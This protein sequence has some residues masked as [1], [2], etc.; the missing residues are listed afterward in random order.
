LVDNI[1]IAFIYDSAHFD[2]VNLITASDILTNVIWEDEG[3]YVWLSADLLNS[4][5]NLNLKNLATVVLKASN[6]GTARFDFQ[7]LVPSNSFNQRSTFALW[8]NVDVLGDYNNSEDGVV[9]AS[10]IVADPQNDIPAY[11]VV[12]GDNIISKG[13]DY[14][15]AIV[16]LTN[17]IIDPDYISIE[18]AWNPADFLYK[19]YEIISSTASFS[20][21]IDTNTGVLILSSDNIN[22][23]DCA[24]TVA[25][26]RLTAIH[27][28][29]TQIELIAPELSAGDG[30]ILL[31]AQANDLLGSADNPN[32]GM[33]GKSIIITETE[34]FMLDFY[35]EISKVKPGEEFF[36]DI[37]LTNLADG[38]LYSNVA[39]MFEYDVDD[40]VILDMSN[41]L[42]A[43][44]VCIEKTNF[45]DFCSM[46]FVWNQPTNV[47]GVLATIKA[48]TISDFPIDF[49]FSFNNI[50]IG[51]FPGSYALNGNEDVL[52]SPEF[53]EDGVGD[54]L[55]LDNDGLP[56]GATLHFFSKTNV[57]VG[58]IF[59][60]QIFLSNSAAV[61]VTGLNLI[62]EVEKESFEVESISQGNLGGIVEI[63]DIDNMYGLVH[64]RESFDVPTLVS[65]VV[66][67]LKMFT[68]GGLNLGTI[69]SLAPSGEFDDDGTFVR[70]N[71]IDVLGWAD[72]EN[73][74]GADTL[75][76]IEVSENDFPILILDDYN[77]YEINSFGSMVVGDLGVAYLENRNIKTDSL[78]WKIEQVKG[79]KAE[80]AQV[81]PVP[82]YSLLIYPKVGSVGTQIFKVTVTDYENSSL[83]SYDYVGLI[84]D[85]TEELIYPAATDKI[86][87]TKPDYS[88]NSKSGKCSFENG[89]FNITGGSDKDSLIIKSIGNYESI[90]SDNGLKKLSFNGSLNNLNIDG[91]IGSIIVKNGNLGNVTAESIKKISITAPRHYVKDEAIFDDIIDEPQGL[92]GSVTC[93]G[94]IGTIIVKSGDVGALDDREDYGQ[95]IISKNGSIGKI[96]T[97]GKKR[98]WFEKDYGLNRY[99]GGGNIYANILAPNGSIKN[100]MANNNIGWD[101]IDQPAIISAANDIKSIKLVWK[102]VRD[103]DAPTFFANVFSTS[104]VGRITIKS[105]NFG[106]DDLQTTIKADSIKSVKCKLW[107]DY[108]LDDG[109][110]WVDIYGGEFYANIIAENS[111]GS[112]GGGGDYFT[113]RILS[114]GDIKNIVYKGYK[115]EEGDLWGGDIEESFIAAGLNAD[116]SRSIGSIKSVKA[117]NNILD[118]TIQAGCVY[119]DPTPGYL[120]TIKKISAKASITDSVI[121]SLE[122]PKFSNKQA[123]AR[124]TYYINGTKQ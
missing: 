36:F 110:P 7:F 121:G 21:N 78:I 52:G 116:G 38:F 112:V 118:S 64:Y 93:E 96:I 55:D 98:Q 24:G 33:F 30:T 80:F 3:G 94:D 89:V 34:A 81:M 71:N 106:T 92:V 56:F 111:I 4:V 8:N 1:G 68:R 40:V 95:T 27:E 32:D 51:V 6:Q 72:D 65:G 57:S 87:Y 18:F 62:F 58:E 77:E 73:D 88:Y 123:R 59:D 42:L 120:G 48:I 97:K 26:V 99:F 25:V 119:A 113:S 19:N 17:L 75:I 11:M 29:S 102:K 44:A 84:I 13:V 115:D 85:P 5:S 43:N 101:N 53:D 22:I 28:G 9:G 105:A 47:L 114:G 117:G 122:R 109:D 70:N 31:D 124:I 12:K 107:R 83:Y 49:M 54:D 76:D 86:T 37:I 14:S 61:K 45:N 10:V 100:I 15:A 50:P 79:D 41:A 46:N 90:N 91:P 35:S 74:G 66:C 39:F 103:G 67:N 16:C 2:F 23:Q 104:D 60:G 63:S 20:H 82:P 69:E 108:Y